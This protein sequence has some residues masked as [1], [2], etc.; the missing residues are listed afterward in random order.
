[1]L[2]IAVPPLR[3]R[4]DDVV[5]LAGTSSTRPGPGWGLAA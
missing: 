1:V 5:M 4:G 2:R 3:V